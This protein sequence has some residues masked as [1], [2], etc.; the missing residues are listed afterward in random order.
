MFSFCFHSFL[1]R[2]SCTL[3]LSVKL[4]LFLSIHVP[5]QIVKDKGGIGH[6][7]DSNGQT[8]GREVRS[9]KYL[10]HNTEHSVILLI[11]FKSNCLPSS[12]ML[13]ALR[14]SYTNTHVLHY[15]MPY[16]TI[17]Y[18]CCQRLRCYC[19]CTCCT[20]LYCCHPLNPHISL[21]Y[22][23]SSS[24][25]LLY[26]LFLFLSIFHR[27]F[28]PVYGPAQWEEREKQRNS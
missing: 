14:K 18:L 25:Y 8:T 27:R 3:C 2:P 24:S 10:W 19:I 17:P 4:P 6:Q 15:T 12:L 13:L 11:S 5:C 1:Y 26:S 20:V 16:H 9:D 23:L 7:I 21:L 28:L 22:I